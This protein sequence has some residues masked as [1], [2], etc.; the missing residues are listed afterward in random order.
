MSFTSTL[1]SIQTKFTTALAYMPLV[2]QTVTSIESAMPS[3]SGTS[4]A[5][6]ALGIILSVAHAGEQI[7]QPTVQ[8][9]AGLIDTMVS[10]LNATGVFKKATPNTTVTV[11][12][13]VA[14]AA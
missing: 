7:P 2:Q 1:A 8:L 14:P 4:K 6:A 5:Q 12:P 3:A 13:T 11:A 10:V 9:I